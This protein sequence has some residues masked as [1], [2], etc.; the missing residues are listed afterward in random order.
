[1]TIHI[2][3]L[4][5]Q[6]ELIKRL[7]EIHDGTFPNYLIEGDA[8]N[9]YYWSEVGLLETFPE[10]QFI[11]MDE[12]NRLLG[13]GHTI[14]LYWDGSPGGLP[15][16]YDTALA[17]GFE[18]NQKPN[19]LC[20]LSIIVSTQYR[21]TGLSQKAVQAMKALAQQ[22][23]FDAVIIPVRPTLKSSYPLIPMDRYITWKN[24]EGFP[25][26]P[27][28]RVH[29]KLGAEIVKIAPQ[30]MVVKGTLTQWEDWTGM[31]FPE[32]GQYIVPGALQPV[33]IN[34]EEDYGRYDDPNVW[35]IHRI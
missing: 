29:E 1:M 9:H 16:G 24:K 17:Q 33:E 19:A 32:S 3:S 26:D 14:P 13:S 22:K 8:I 20:G 5:E 11:L 15:S 31:V 12:E 18:G 35:M 21:G 25:F 27:W 7:P 30:S 2:L 34:V 10:Y 4:Q 23:N 28:L 6:P